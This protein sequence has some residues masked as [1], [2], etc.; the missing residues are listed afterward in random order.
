[1]ENPYLP[2]PVVLKQ[3]TFENDARDVK[4]FDLVFENPEHAKSF[5]FV[6]GQFVM[7]SINGVGEAP[8]GIAS[9]PMDADAIQVTV[10]KY[11][12]G[13]VTTALYNLSVG[14]RL[15][16]RGPFGNGYPT[17]E[18]KSKN[19]LVIGGGFALTTLRSFVRY[20]LDEKN[21][22]EFGKLT[23]FVAAREPG[24]ILYKKDIAGWSKRH[25][26]EVVQTI[27][28]AADGWKG[29][30]GYAAVV[31]KQL[32]PQSQNTYTLICGPP[33]MIKTCIAVLAKCGR[34]NVGSKYVCKDGPV[35]SYRQLQELSAEY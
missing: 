10:K 3:T 29:K 15:G 34:C 4:T 12:K 28:S 17:E 25:D 13:V 24:E 33:I 7:V 20:V 18:L 11:P 5:A 1:M 22:N 14:D 16:L 6:S 8:F 2:M 30:V 27:D 31:L 32:A 9:C 23:V 26:V 35:F 19:I 21:R